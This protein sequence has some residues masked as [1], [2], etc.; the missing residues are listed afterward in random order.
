MTQRLEGIEELPLH[1]AEA[2]Q[3]ALRLLEVSGQDLLEAEGELGCGV[4]AGTDLEQD[5][6]KARASAEAQAD[7]LRQAAD[8]RK[9]KLSVWWNDLQRSWNAHIAKIREDV[10]TKR[11]EHDVGRA[12]HR[13]ERAEDDAAFAIDYAIAAIEEAEYAVLDATLARQK[14]DELSKQGSGAPA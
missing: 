1:P 14:A 9:G 8:E 2:F 13:A 10:D 11:A 4:A 6:A 7:K 12:E 3:A 5:V